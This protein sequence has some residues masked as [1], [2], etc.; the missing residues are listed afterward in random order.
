MI[1]QAGMLS[2]FIL[3]KVCTELYISVAY[4]L[5]SVYGIHFSLEVSI[6]QY[7]YVEGL[8]V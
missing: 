3:W 7:T 2:V 1:A 8:Y 4:Q 6:L 5:C